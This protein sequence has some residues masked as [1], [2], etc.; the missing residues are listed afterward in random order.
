MIITSSM[1]MATFA[2]LK[3]ILADMTTMDR[4]PLGA[5]ALVN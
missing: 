2:H 1:M 5:G 3:S 4:E